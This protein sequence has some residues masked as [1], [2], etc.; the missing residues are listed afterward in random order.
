MHNIDES[1]V[2]IILMR[3]LSVLQDTAGSEADKVAAVSCLFKTVVEYMPVTSS[4]RS[5]VTDILGFADNLMSCPCSGT[6]KPEFIACREF[7]KNELTTNK[8]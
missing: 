2:R 6:T 4:L 7:V 8:N 1:R 3:F 5:A